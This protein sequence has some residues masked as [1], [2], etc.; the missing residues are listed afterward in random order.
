MIHVPKTDTNEVKI[1]KIR[2]GKKQ[3]SLS[4]FHDEE[5]ILQLLIP[6]NFGTT[7]VLFSRDKILHMKWCGLEKGQDVYSLDLSHDVKICE[8]HFAF[9]LSFETFEGV[10][11]LSAP[12]GLSDE[13]TVF[14]T[15]KEKSKSHEL[16]FTIDK[17]DSFLPQGC[18]YHVFIDRFK[19]S[20]DKVRSDSKYNP[21]WECGIPE[22]AENGVPFDNNTHFGGGFEGIEKSIDYLQKLSVETIYLSPVNKGFSNHKYDVGSYFEIDENFGGEEKLVSLCRECKR[23][24]IKVV[25][26][27]VFNHTGDNSVYFNK[28]S[29]YKTVGAYNST[30]SPY[31]NWYTF[32][33]HPN[34]YDSWWGIGC[35]PSIK[36]GSREFMDFI[37]QENGVIDYYFK[38]GANG[39]RLDVA[40]ELTLEFI[41]RIKEACKRNDKNSIVVGEVWDNATRKRAWDEDKFYFDRFKLDSVTNYP[42]MRSILDFVKNKNSESLA[43]TVA[44]IY[45][46]YPFFSSLRLFNIISTHDT[47]RAITYLASPIPKRKSER[48]GFKMSKEDFEKGITMMK[49]ASFLQTF[50]PGV[51]CIYYGDEI[52]MQGF[53]D[54]F[55]RMPMKWHEIHKPLLDWYQKIMKI[56]KENRPL[57][58]G[59]LKV[60]HCNDGYIIFDRTIENETVRLFVNCSDKNL[61]FNFKG[62]D[63]INEKEVTKVIVSSMECSVLRL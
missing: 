57:Y 1:R 28:Y 25:F 54:P 7:D 45:T 16:I 40:D 5:F 42:L 33:S 63:L 6:R 46:D 56:R 34:S 38:L 21:D 48:A 52:G 4:S 50:L 44:E 13:D 26:D 58:K 53:E 3:T 19:K 49:C 55:C 18:V 29:T 10:F 43:K 2:S 35:L 60:K 51:P 31:Y 61:S 9:Y 11:Y 22:F 37:C 23:N 41:K 17:E 36:K 27:S 59:G 8:E 20:S 62:Y 47:H 30:A 14:S 12:I 15:T 24:N 32:H 39:L